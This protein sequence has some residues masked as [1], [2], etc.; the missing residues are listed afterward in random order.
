M[1][2]KED[3]H[4]NELPLSSKKGDEVNLEDISKHTVTG[5]TQHRFMKG[6][7]CLM[8]DGILQ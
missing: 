4:T 3:L 6:T 1:G 5:S 8:N 7:S 2:K